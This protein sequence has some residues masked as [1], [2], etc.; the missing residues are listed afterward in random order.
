[1]ADLLAQTV[2]NLAVV[3]TPRSAVM[4]VVSRS[5][6]T[7]WSTVCFP[8]QF[9]RCA[10]PVGPWWKQLLLEALEKAGFF[11][12]S[13]DPKRL[14]GIELHFILSGEDRERKGSTVCR[15][16]LQDMHVPV[17]VIP[18]KAGICSA[19]LRICDVDGLDSR[20]RGNDGC[21][22]TAPHAK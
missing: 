3:L 16:H 12:F 21:L 22:Q 14:K 9:P 10:P 7:D 11:S 20:F 6:R 15:C 17:A 13:L 2:K 19:R 1:M 8:Q 18:A 4:S 5:S